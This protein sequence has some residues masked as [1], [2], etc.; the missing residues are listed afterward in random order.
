MCCAGM[1][2][3]YNDFKL[4]LVLTFSTRIRNL[5]PKQNINLYI[6]ILIINDFCC[7]FA[8]S[9]IFFRIVTRINYLLCKLPL[10]DY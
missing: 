9:V 7:Y 8:N 2:S 6:I 1:R 10:N 3:S 4:G 5:L